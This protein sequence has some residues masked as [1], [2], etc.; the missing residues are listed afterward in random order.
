M[1]VAVDTSQIV[2]DVFAQTDSLDLVA[3]KIAGANESVA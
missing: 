3:G 1:T 2:C